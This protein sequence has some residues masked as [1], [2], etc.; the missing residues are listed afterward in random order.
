MIAW[1]LVLAGLVV[2]GVDAADFSF[3]GLSL[4]ALLLI[5]VGMWVGGVFDRST[6]IGDDATNERCALLD[7][8][9]DHDHPQPG[10]RP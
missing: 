4:I 8:A 9:I 3:N 1:V 6:W 7:Y 2:L 10:A 5:G